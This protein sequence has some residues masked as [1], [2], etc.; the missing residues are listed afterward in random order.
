MSG[1]VRERPCGRPGA[2]CADRGVGRGAVGER[3]QASRR[4]GPG[5]DEAPKDA[6]PGWAEPGRA[7]P[8]RG[9]RED[10]KGGGAATGRT[11]AHVCVRVCARACAMACVREGCLLGYGGEHL[12]KRELPLPRVLR[13]H[14]RPRNHAA[15]PRA[16][17]RHAP[18]RARA[19]AHPRP[20]PHLYPPAHSP[21]GLKSLSRP[22]QPS[23]RFRRRRA[24]R[25]RAC[26]HSLS[27]KKRA[28]RSARAKLPQTRRPGP[29]APGR[30][31]AAPAR[32]GRGRRP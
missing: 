27:P 16:R 22:W 29:R 32:G 3:E 11:C 10:S 19:C 28:D 9:R 20:R 6:G 30:P 13:L 21:P 24:P 23:T 31:R 8:R 15:A 5:R 4:A 26:A 12:L 2:G 7:G 17:P 1:R 14:T 18:A 25:A